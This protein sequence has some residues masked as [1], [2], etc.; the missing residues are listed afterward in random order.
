M[1]DGHQDC[2]GAEDE[3]SCGTTGEGDVVSA[4]SYHPRP[5]RVPRPRLRPQPLPGSS[6][7]TGK[8]IVDLSKNLKIKLL[9]HYLIFQ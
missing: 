2:P 8:I 4:A 7:Y 6:I 9:N 3:A 1:C 5:A